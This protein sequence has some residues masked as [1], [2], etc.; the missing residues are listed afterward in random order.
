MINLSMCQSIF[1]SKTTIVLQKF[2][3]IN[4]KMIMIMVG[5]KIG[6]LD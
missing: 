2:V 1:S 6:K 4:I 5:H 3:E